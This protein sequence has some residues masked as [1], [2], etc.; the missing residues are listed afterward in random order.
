[1]LALVQN[2]MSLGSSYGRKHVPSRRN[3]TTQ[4]KTEIV[5]E[6]LKLS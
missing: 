3:V 5:K 1:M 6:D 4:L 2:F